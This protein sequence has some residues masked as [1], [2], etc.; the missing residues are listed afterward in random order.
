MARRIETA[1]RALALMTVLSATHACARGSRESSPPQSDAAAQER[2]ADT[3]LAHDPRDAAVHP[4]NDGIVVEPVITEHCGVPA[5]T[6]YFAS[7]STTLRPGGEERLL[8]IARCLTVGPLAQ[9]EIVLVGHTD[10]RGDEADNEAL[11]VARARAVR[12]FLRGHG[13]SSLKMKVVSLGE[14]DAG[15]DESS[16]VRDRRVE[17]EL[18]P[19]GS[20]LWQPSGD[21]LAPAPPEATR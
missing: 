1:T 7:G 16:W 4:Q 5:T 6:A 19:A 13:V 8:A 21:P 20:H 2:G 3:Q 17:L 18:V 10:P 15:T 14:R 11:G 9:R 12:D